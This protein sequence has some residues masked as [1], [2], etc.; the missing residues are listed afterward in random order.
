MKNKSFIQIIT[1]LL[2]YFVYF[3]IIYFKIGFDKTLLT[4][5]IAPSC[6]LSIGVGLYLRKERFYKFGV[7]FFTVLFIITSYNI[8]RL[9]F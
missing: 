5:A 9:I 6:L 1:G 8:F 2:L 4:L 3:G 7:L